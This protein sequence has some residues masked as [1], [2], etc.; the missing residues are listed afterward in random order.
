MAAY[1]TNQVRHLYVV[2]AVKDS[3]LIPSDA[4]GTIYV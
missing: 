3:H 4:V 2:K 1:S